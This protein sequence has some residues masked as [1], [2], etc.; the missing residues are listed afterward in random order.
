MS[1]TAV[2]I[3]LAVSSICELNMTGHRRELSIL[4]IC[5]TVQLLLLRQRTTKKFIT[6]L[7]AEYYYTSDYYEYFYNDFKLLSSWSQSF[8]LIR[9]EHKICGFLY[10]PH[11]LRHFSWQR[12]HPFFCSLALVQ[13]PAHILCCNIL[14]S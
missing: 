3:Y 10:Q 13:H 7:A 5:I 1:A 11:L 4:Y 6:L 9:T 12:H 8:F 2:N 14:F